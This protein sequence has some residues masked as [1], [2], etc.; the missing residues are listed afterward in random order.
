MQRRTILSL[1]IGT[2]LA[3]SVGIGQAK[4]GHEIKIG[5]VGSK[6]GPL[7]AGAAVTHWP[8]Y[9]LWEKEVNARGGFNINGKT[10][11][12]KASKAPVHPERNRLSQNP[13][14]RQNPL[15]S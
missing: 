10:A 4:A 11:S 12:S 13:A 8:P 14:G 9:R 15:F 7:A 6:T 1:A 5:V 2:A 3:V